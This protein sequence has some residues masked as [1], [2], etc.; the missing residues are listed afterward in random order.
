MAVFVTNTVAID[1][2]VIISTGTLFY[3]N[4]QR[5]FKTVQDCT[6]STSTKEC[7]RPCEDRLYSETDHHLFRKAH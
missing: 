7:P 4:H 3:N 1:Y 5:A 6:L 2:G